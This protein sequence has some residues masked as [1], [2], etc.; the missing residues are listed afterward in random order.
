LISFYRD[1]LNEREEG[2]ETC[3]LSVL[4]IGSRLNGILGQC[5]ASGN[6]FPTLS[7][8]TAGHRTT[9]F[10]RRCR[11]AGVRN[12]QMKSYRYG[13]AERARVAGMPEREAM[14]HLG[15]KSRA[16]HAAYAGGAQVAV[17]PLEYYEEQRAK[18]VIEFGEAQRNFESN[19]DHATASRA[20]AG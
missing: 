6:L 1:K 4:A 3:G 10:S 16:I 7:Q 20:K 19:R 9:E 17:L 11:T 13:W 14:N 12:R 2:G 15:H 8:W 5:P 18:K